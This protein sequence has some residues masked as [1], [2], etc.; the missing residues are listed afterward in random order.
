[1][2]D[3]LLTAREVKQLLKDI[4]HHL[5]EANKKVGNLYL[6]VQEADSK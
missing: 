4:N 1:M 2:N 6:W 5:T 3:E